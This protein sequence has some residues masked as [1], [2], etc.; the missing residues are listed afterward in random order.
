MCNVRLCG[1]DFSSL[2]SYWQIKTLL[3]LKPSVVTPQNQ[4]FPANAEGMSVQCIVYSVFSNISLLSAG[5][6]YIALLCHDIKV[7][8]MRE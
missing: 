4:P 6:G 7:Y 1:M 2:A 5:Y 8:L 3:K